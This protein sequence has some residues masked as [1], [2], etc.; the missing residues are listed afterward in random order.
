MADSAEENASNEYK[1]S[2]A[3]LEKIIQETIENPIDSDPVPII[4]ES[5]AIA[6]DREYT[7]LL[8]KFLINYTKEKKQTLIQ[9]SLFF[10]II[11]AFLSLLGVAG[12]V[13]LFLSLYSD[14]VNT[15]P[16][17]IGACVDI[18]GS[19][20]AIP[21]IIAKHLFPEKIDEKII[22]V[23]TV[24]V[25]NDKHVRAARENRWHDNHK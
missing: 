1:S 2:S 24:L 18:F 5:G 8:E 23:V 22:D 17:I 4:G 11:V 7:L 10:G 16:V 21:T 15:L 3:E 12:I 20:I 19:F 25:D 9:K 14:S 6:R 13:L